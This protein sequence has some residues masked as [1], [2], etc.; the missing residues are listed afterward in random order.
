MTRKKL[1]VEDFYH[2]FHGHE[3][4]NDAGEYVKPKHHLKNPSLAAK[5]K[6]LD[7]RS[8]AGRHVGRKAVAV[9]KKIDTMRLELTRK[10]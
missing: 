2:Q 8:L 5:H 1:S 9:H 10:K 7:L 6:G 3:H 4:H